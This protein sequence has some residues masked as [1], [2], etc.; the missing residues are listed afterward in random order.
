[1]RNW[2]ETFDLLKSKSSKVSSSRVTAEV[3]AYSS[4]TGISPEIVKVMEEEGQK[5][6][7]LPSSKVKPL[8]R[9]TRR[10]QMEKDHAKWLKSP[11]AV[12]MEKDH[13]KWLKSP[14]AAQMDR[15][16]A[17][18]LK[19]P[20]AA[21]MDKDHAKWL[22]SPE[23]EQ[24]DKD[25][26][27]WLNTLVEKGMSNWD[28]TLDLLKGTSFDKLM[29][30][31]VP[32]AHDIK[33][34][35]QLK[36]IQEYIDKL[37]AYKKKSGETLTDQQG[38][39][40]HERIRNLQISVKEGATFLLRGSP[41]IKLPINAEKARKK[42]RSAKPGLTKIIEPPR[43]G[44]QP[45]S[46]EYPESRKKTW[47]KEVPTT[48]ALPE[49]M[50]AQGEVDIEGRHA[51]GVGKPSKR[52]VM[53]TLTR[54]GNL[55]DLLGLGGKKTASLGVYS[56]P[57]QKQHEK[58]IREKMLKQ[59]APRNW[60]SFIT[61]L[62]TLSPGTGG[63]SHEVYPTKTEGVVKRGKTARQK[64]GREAGEFRKYVAE[65]TTAG[66]KVRSPRIQKKGWEALVQKPR[67]KGSFSVGDP[68]VKKSLYVASDAVFMKGH[69]C[70]GCEKCKGKHEGKK[71]SHK[72]KHN[73]NNAYMLKQNLH[74]I[75]GNA[76][77]LHEMLDDEHDVPKWADTKAAV[78]AD[79]VNTLNRYLSYK[80]ERGH[81]HKSITSWFES[82][83]LI[84]KSGWDEA[85]D[86]LDPKH[87]H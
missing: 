26:A 60:A 18:W 10:E 25:H 47:T 61:E 86:L 4:A 48:A 41:E 24:M 6:E 84:Y 55:L 29:T 23:A 33:D 51:K 36:N 72:E 75:A 39:Q 78:A 85:N 68:P 15:D 50:Q 30:F 38:D 53:N 79:K 31:K 57:S 54:W 56:K 77:E 37:K 62:A 28:Q 63:A 65:H 13:K 5:A 40:L 11:E 9:I 52:E 16:H 2:S 58:H 71:H 44:S 80:T 66:G 49:R 81:M 35:V 64:A 27:K 67:K 59:N 14:E 22:K 74:N 76:A 1:M 20:E 42:L 32:E 46:T 19:S 70:K 21:Q 69:S 34:E 3:P 12:Q 7:S 87:G 43:E 83:E 45:A 8:K 17:E 73:D 82:E